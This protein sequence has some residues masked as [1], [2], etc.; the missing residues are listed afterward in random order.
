MGY[1]DLLDVAKHFQGVFVHIMTNQQ[2]IDQS[3]GMAI[4][5][6]ENGYF[7]SCD[8]YFLY[9]SFEENGPVTGFVPI[10]KILN[11]VRVDHIQDLM[12]GEEGI[13]PDD[14]GMDQ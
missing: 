3:T 4:N 9:Y 14:E 11:V 6:S 1:K 12:E 2:I 13:E 8:G 7:Q 10:D 5:Y